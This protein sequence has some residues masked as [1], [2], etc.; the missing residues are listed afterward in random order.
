MSSRPAQL[1]RPLSPRVHAGLAHLTSALLMG[2]ALLA[3]QPAPVQAASALLETVKE[4]PAL[5]Q[6]LC[7]RFKQFNAQGKLATSKE[8]IAWVAADQGLSPVD[9]EVL[10]TY[11]IGLH[12]PDV[13]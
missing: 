6:R 9:A 3:L 2:G 13:R 8:S 12:C 4:N 7:E 5:R 1:L 10:S 11:V